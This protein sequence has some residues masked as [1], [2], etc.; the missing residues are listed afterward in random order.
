MMTPFS[1]ASLNAFNRLGEPI[2]VAKIVV[3]LPAMKPKGLVDK[4]IGLNGAMA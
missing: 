3:F 1:L 2:D 4:T